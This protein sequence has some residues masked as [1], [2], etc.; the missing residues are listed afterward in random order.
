M[1]KPYYVGVCRPYFSNKIRYKWNI[2]EN[3]DCL[4]PDLIH[5]IYFECIAKTLLFPLAHISAKNKKEAKEQYLERY[6]YVREIVGK[7]SS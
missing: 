7:I 5:K 6:P 4:S 3:R 1:T 2:T